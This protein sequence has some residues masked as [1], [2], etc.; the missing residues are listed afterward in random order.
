[1]NTRTERDALG[2]LEIP[3]NLYY[4]IHTFRSL[5]NFDAAGARLP[6]EI[7]H[8]AVRLKLACARANAELGQIDAENAAAIESACGRVLAGE[9]DDQFVIDVFQAGSGTSSNMNVNE[10]LANIANEQLGGRKGEYSPIHP[11]DHVNMGQST[12]NIIPSSIRVALLAGHRQF[13]A[14]AGDLLD[15]LRVKERDFADILKSGRTHLQDAVPLTLGQEFGAYARAVE[16]SLGRLETAKEA[17]LEL[18]VGGNAVGTG[19]NTKACFRELIVKH[20]NEICSAADFRVAGNGIEATQFLTDLAAFSSALRLLAAD[21]NKIANDLRLLSSGPNTGLAEIRLPAVEPGSSIMPGKINPSI[22]EAANMACIKVMG[23]DHAI[24]IA[25]AAGQL[26]LN[27]HM[28][29][30]GA[31]L[32]DSQGVLAR[33]C[34]MLAAKCIA[35]IAADRERCL[36]N[37]NNSAGLATVLNPVL[38]YAKVS[39][40]VKASLAQSR[41]VRELVLEQGLLDEAEIDKLFAQSTGPRQ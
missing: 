22:C 32:I 40:L 3:D 17:L 39:E 28:P 18:G 41:S 16:K 15:T 21:V 9:F 35:G 10:V 30:V 7:I 26:E 20:L 34:R 2:E 14:A 8:A 27:T 4:G 37:F 13:M 11:N 25:A 36:G 31:L 5:N 23:N 19:I 12:N 33:C 38:G 29:L 24:G 1:M 6:I